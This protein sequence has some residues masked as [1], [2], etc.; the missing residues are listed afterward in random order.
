MLAAEVTSWDG[1]LA[2]LR[3]GKAHLECVAGG[4]DI[5]VG[6]IPL[7]VW[8]CIRAE[9]VTLLYGAGQASSARNRLPGRVRTVDIEGPLARVEL[10]CGFPM[11]AAITAQSADEMKLRTG[12]TVVAAVKAAAMHLI[13]G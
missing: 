9:D 1:G 11:V 5:E 7:R 2:R 12:D 13:R 3:I 6:Q 8:A 10:D 4:A